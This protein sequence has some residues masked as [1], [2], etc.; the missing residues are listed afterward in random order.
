MPD[1]AL[2]DIPEKFSLTPEFR[3]LAACSWVAPPELEQDQAER[4]A[5]LCAAGIDWEE[6]LILARRHAVHALAYAAL[7]RHAGE[8]VPPAVQEALRRHNSATRRQALFQTAE[9]VRLTRLFAGRGI[10][11]IPLKGVFLSH[12]IYGDMGLRSSVDLDILVQEADV[13][14]AEQVLAAEGYSC[15]SHGLELTPRQKRHIRTHIH[16]YDFVHPE[17]GLHVELHWNF[18]PWLPGQLA[19]LLSRVVRQEWQGVSFDC[20]DDDATLLFMCD[21]GARQEWLKLKWLGDVARLLSSGRTT[22][23]HTLLALAQEV[24]L[25]RTLA[26]SALLAHWVYGIPLPDELRALILRERLAVPLSEGALAALLMSADEV[27]AAGKRAQRMRLAWITKR[28]RPSLPYGL[29]LSSCLVPPE[30]FQMLN[31]PAPLFWLHYPL[32]PFLW[33]WR[34]Y[35]RR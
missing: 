31:L 11:L 15:D 8:A 23:R 5:S 26:H 14:R 6:F 35:I 4:I 25:Q 2:P 12:R 34:N 3:L 33:F 24:D 13:E 32:R 28:L 9:L 19:A 1:P 29:V 16:H 10:G 27:A 17:S 18:G 7:G 21:H 30:D 20:L 22:G